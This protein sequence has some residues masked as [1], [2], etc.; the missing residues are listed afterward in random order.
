VNP[1]SIVNNLADEVSEKLEVS[2]FKFK[3][4]FLNYLMLSY[5]G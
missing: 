4:L 5:K 3:E 2:K 1:F